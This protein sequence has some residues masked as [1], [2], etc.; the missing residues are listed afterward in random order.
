[1]R[2]GIAAV[3]V[4]L[5]GCTGLDVPAIEGYDAIRAAIEIRTDPATGTMIASSAPAA[6]EEIFRPT[7][8]DGMDNSGTFTGVLP[9]DRARSKFYVEGHKAADGSVQVY[10][11]SAGQTPVM[12]TE[13]Q[14]K[15]WTETN[16]DSHG[17]VG[18]PWRK[19]YWEL[20]EYRHECEGAKRTCVRFKT[21]R[22]KLSE[23]DVRAL[24]AEGRDEI[25]VSL[26]EYRQVSSRLDVD[27][28]TAVLDALGARESFK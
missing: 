27:Q 15:P 24:L 12:E 10:F 14:E 26:G 5:T 8:V 16:P 6:K 1:M 23:E 18:D 3:L 11:V 19:V 28:L 13:A 21:D 25:R 17:Y 22:M 9:S 4:V 20:V 7:Y 2:L